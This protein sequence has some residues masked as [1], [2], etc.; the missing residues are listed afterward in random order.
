FCAC[1]AC[2][3]CMRRTACA[4]STTESSARTRAAQLPID[5]TT[6]NR[7]M[8]SARIFGRASATWL[9][10]VAAIAAGVG[11]WIGLRQLSVPALPQLEAAT[12]YPAPRA[13]P[14][15]TLTQ[16][17]GSPLTLADWKG[18]WSVVFF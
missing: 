12:A 16:G 8:N 6:Y 3:N 4:A 17:N 11:L 13:I 14:D 15:F 18:H 10:L 1:F 5:H 9:I 7:A 2:A